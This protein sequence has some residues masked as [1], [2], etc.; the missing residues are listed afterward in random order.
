LPFGDSDGINRQRIRELRRDVRL[1]GTAVQYRMGYLTE[2]KLSESF[3]PFTVFRGYFGF[4][5][6]LWRA[7][8]LLPRLIE[9]EAEL[10]G[11]ILCDQRS[12]LP[13]ILK[14][15]TLFAL[16]A[17]Q[18]NRY[19]A[20]VGRQMLLLLGMPE[21]L[22]D[23]L[24]AGDWTADL[25]PMDASL[26]SFAVKLC[27]RG[28][29]IARADIARLLALGITEASVL[30]AVLLAAWGSFLRILWIGLGAEPDFPPPPDIAMAPFLDVLDQATEEQSSNP[31]FSPREMPNDFGPFAFLRDNFG[32]IPNVFR[33]QALFPAAV[34]AEVKALSLI[35]LTDDLLKRIEKERIL[36]AVS[37][38][39]QNTYCVAVY[40]E[41]L[42]LL[43]V[44]AE[45]SY[46]IAGDHRRAG[47]SELDHA[48][49]EFAIKLSARSEEFSSDD[50]ESL[51]RQG[52]SS[53]QILEAVAVT[54][55]TQFLN[56]VQQGTGAAP[57]FAPSRSFRVGDK[58]ANPS[59]V[60]S[61]RT[62]VE[63]LV[64]PDLELV[65][66]AKAG[67]LQ[68]FE[69][70]VESHSK[71][72][73]RTLVGLLRSPEEARDAMQDTFLKAFQHLPS[74]QGRSKF[75]TWLLSIASNTGLQKLR[76]RRPLE[77]IDGEGPESDEGFQPRQVRAWT[78]DPEQLYSHAEVQSLVEG[79]VMRLPPK[80]RVVVMLRD[81]EQLSAEDAAAALGLGIPA[82]KS[83][84][85]R[86]R[87]MLREA[88][89]PHFAKNPKGAHG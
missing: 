60:D 27:A 5:P 80:Y 28:P 36:L 2:A 77:S 45:E 13:Q 10:I 58:N 63:Q 75:S 17:V 64:D 67:D 42:T 52:L 39:N 14:E 40:A 72:V 59:T 68:A 78:E 8:T 53:E 55:F 43:G 83:R 12:H 51:R 61:R 38:A 6:N 56:T 30:E 85:S 18:R 3:P 16:A 57:D 71:R 37:G 20:T 33:A 48:L 87:L 31:Y 19:S 4:V 70:L 26:L 69:S 66:K 62:E 81:L 47:L 1:A 74:F 15:R 35:L 82:L 79:Y 44:S 29:F 34:A 88:L 21:T 11:A 54:A 24:V 84:L 73:Y 32:F 9:A 23:R 7:Q 50:I 46:Q 49:L 65:Q 76:E 89:A 22:L 25:S 41:I 86:G